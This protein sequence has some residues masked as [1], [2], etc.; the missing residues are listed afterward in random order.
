M[1]KDL[2]NSCGKGFSRT[3]VIYIRLL[4]IKYPKSQTLSDQLSW[5]HYVELLGVTDKLDGT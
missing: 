3:N 1:A 5:S 4:Y 2:K